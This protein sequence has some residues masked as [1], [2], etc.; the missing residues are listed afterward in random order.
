MSPRLRATLNWP[1]TG[2]VYS[3]AL[4]PDGQLLAACGLRD[5][6]IV[7]W[8]LHERKPIRTI[9]TVGG[10]TYSLAFTPDGRTLA[11]SFDHQEVQ[12]GKLK[13][14]GG[15]ALFDVPTGKAQ[16]MLNHD[17][18]RS[19][20]RMAIAPDGKSVAAVEGTS[21]ETTRYKTMVTL[22]DLASGKVLETLPDDSC[23][24]IAFSPDAKVLA[25][26]IMTWNK[27]GIDDCEI[28]LRFL[29]AGKELP[30]LKDMGKHPA[31]HLAYSPNGTTFA[32]G[33][34]QGNIYL[35]NTLTGQLRSKLVNPDSRR[36]LSM[37]FSP[38][39]AKLAVAAGSRPSHKFDSGLIALWDVRTGKALETLSGHQGQVFNLAFTPDGQT[40]VSTGVDKTIR[41][42]DV[43]DL[44]VT[45]KE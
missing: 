5:P 40:L 3:L 37:A 35:W 32:A 21:D 31:N 25:R 12:A 8:N 33:D 10:E 7:L 36:V 34:D 39:G 22:W 14:S 38:D 44:A 41:L 24:S 19:V 42:W 4:S 6:L 29:P 28:R 13:L 27:Q 23:Q 26:S 16:G 18:P 20:S 17:P 15:V 30:P 2:V 43:R 9:K 1:G 45:R 11:A